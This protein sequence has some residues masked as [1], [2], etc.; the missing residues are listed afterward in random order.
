MSPDPIDFG[1]AP[2]VPP[3]EGWTVA[4]V[5]AL[6]DRDGVRY[7]L[8]DGVPHVMTPPRME[9]QEALLELH[10]ALR[11]TAPPDL[12]VVQGLGVVLAEDQ[13]RSRTSSW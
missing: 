1:T 9:H 4:D 6:P 7:E 13:D 8:V 5:D 12:R 3:Q 11:A 10:L 2:T